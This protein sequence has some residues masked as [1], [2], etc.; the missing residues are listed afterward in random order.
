MALFSLG[1][2]WCNP[3]LSLVFIALASAG[4][5]TALISRGVRNN[6]GGWVQS[7][8]QNSCGS[9]IPCVLLFAASFIC[10]TISFYLNVNSFTVLQTS[11]DT[12]FS[13]I[14]HTWSASLAYETTPMV[15][16]FRIA[17]ELNG[18][19]S[20]RY[21]MITSVSLLPRLRVV[22]FVSLCCSRVVYIVPQNICMDSLIS[23]VAGLERMHMPLWT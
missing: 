23:E 6:A 9:W 14:F 8:K 15:I 3:I 17:S 20:Y 21:S 12:T 11:F 16:L 18:F 22:I 19:L 4:L 2:V 7:S 1:S 10:T 5:L 13:P